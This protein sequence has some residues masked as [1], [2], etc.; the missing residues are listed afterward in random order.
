MISISNTDTQ[1]EHIE[2]IFDG[3]TEEY[4]PF[5][6]SINTR[7]DPYSV[8]EVESLLIA[9]EVRMAKHNKIKAS[10][11]KITVNLVNSDSKEKTSG[12]TSKSNQAGNNNQNG[13]RGNQYNNKE[14]E[15]SMGLVAEETEM[16]DDMSPVNYATNPIMWL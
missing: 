9:Q 15:T 7:L 3:L 14:V 1:A 10:N 2:F 6:M 5:I 11:E 13:F 12:N 16:E 4:D 8:S